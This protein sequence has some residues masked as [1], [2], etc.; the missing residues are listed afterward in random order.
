ML[1]QCTLDCEIGVSDTLHIRSMSAMDVTSTETCVPNSICLR[2]S[3][4]DLFPTG[5]ARLVM[6]QAYV[7]A[8]KPDRKCITVTGSTSA[9][10]FYGAVS[11]ISL[12]QG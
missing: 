11:L 10:V 6:E 7:L 9:G 8:I 4:S 2:L 12:L 3:D 5:T 1:A